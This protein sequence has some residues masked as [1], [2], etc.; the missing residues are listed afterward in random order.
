MIIAPTILPPSPRSLSEEDFEQITDIY[1]PERP[2][3]GSEASS[4]AAG[5][6]VYLGAPRTQW[7]RGTPL[8]PIFDG[9]VR[10]IEEHH[11][12]VID[13]NTSYRG[14]TYRAHRAIT[15]NGQLI[16]LRR[17][18]VECPR[19]TDLNL[20][21]F[22][23]PIL[24]HPS[25]QAGGLVVIAAETGQGKST[26]AAA[27]VKSRLEK[28]HGFAWTVE[29]PAEAPLDG[30]YGP[31]GEGVCRQSSVNWTHPDEKER[32]WAGALRAAM[33]AFP[34]TRGNILFVGEVRDGETAAE[35]IQAAING[36]LVITTVHALSIPAA[37]QRLVSLANSRLDQIAPDLLS[38]A[39]RVVVTQQL[40]L[41][42]TGTGWERGSV[43][44]KLV[45]CD[46]ESHPIAVAIRERRYAG[47]L[48]AA[49]HQENV[50]RSAPGQHKGLPEIIR[51]LGS[52]P[53]R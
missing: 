1:L 17:V 49:R 41:R 52:S 3:D 2:I 26:T 34:T 29:D 12:D 47:I 25:L 43:E 9:L 20:P 14:A 19:L 6:W 32:G 31:S 46:G 30:V 11:A 40:L 44:G 51:D 5:A 27:M 45:W 13:F 18:P 36:L 7:V 4:P 10:H 48:Q 42:P 53:D 23:A 37:V 38:T 35:L 24:L 15:R 33:R 8:Q 16:N 39:L 22:W 28:F 50:L 21:P